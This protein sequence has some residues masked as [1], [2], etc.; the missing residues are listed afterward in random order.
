[1]L[2]GLIEKVSGKAIEDVAAHCD[3]PCAI[4]DPAP[5]LISALTVVRMID[6]MEE[7]EGHKPESNIAYQNTMSRCVAQ[8]E[9]HAESVKHDVRIIWGDYLKAPQF[10]KFPNAHELVHNIM[11]TGSKCKQ[12]VSR[13]DALQLVS[14][15]NEFAELFWATKGVDTKRATCPYK[16]SLETV[17]PVL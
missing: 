12:G 4:Y 10:E 1:M 16:P 14:L 15:C 5:L 6:I 11:L 9:E 2:H 7:L 17:Y 13:D 3:V 8:K